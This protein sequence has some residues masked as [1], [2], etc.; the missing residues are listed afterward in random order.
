MPA[1]FDATMWADTDDR[2]KLYHGTAGRH[3]ASILENGLVPR[4]ELAS[5]WDAASSSQHVYLTSAYGIYF[6]QSARAAADEDL[7]IVEIDTDLLDSWDLFADEDAVWFEVNSSKSSLDIALPAGFFGSSKEEQV[8]HL[9]ARLEEIADSGFGYKESL[10]MMGNCAHQGAVPLEAITR[11]VTYSASEGCWW[12]AFHDPVVSVLNFRFHKFE[13]Q[14]TQLVAAD[15]L[16]EA[17]AIPPDMFGMVD[18]KAINEFC[19]SRR[20]VIDLKGASKPTRS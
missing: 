4:A 9:S 3:L 8:M 12:L 14:A 16:D 6:A 13:Y 2:M 7:V 18:L 17:L 10:A 1:N 11:V 20:T 19:A 5:N 15:R